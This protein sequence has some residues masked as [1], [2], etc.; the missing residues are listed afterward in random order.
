MNAEHVNAFL[1][2]SVQV[3]RKMARVDVRLGKVS[4]I[5]ALRLGDNLS[6]VIGL[7]GPLSGSVILTAPPE[8]AR[9]LTSRI[10]REDLDGD[11]DV[12]TILA[13]VANTIVGNATGNL[14]ELGVREGITPP[15]VVTGQDVELGSGGAVETVRVALETDVG[16]VLMIVSLTREDP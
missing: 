8:V 4:R 3:I 15:T 16:Q 2:P 6:I 14:Y 9:R 1:V 13:E 11:G 5:R 10:A 12:R 7:Q